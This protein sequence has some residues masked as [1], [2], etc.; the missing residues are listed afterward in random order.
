MMDPKHFRAENTIGA[1]KA[2]FMSSRAGPAALFAFLKEKRMDFE[3]K[4]RDTPE[5]QA[6]KDL[7]SG[8]Y[9]VDRE[10]LTKARRLNDTLAKPL[11]SLGKLEEIRARLW[12]IRKGELSGFKKAVL[13][14]AG[15]N[16]V[17]EERVSFN[18]QDTTHKVCQ[19]IL[20]GRS[21]LGRIAAYYGVDVYLEDLAVL[22]DVEGHAAFKVRRSTGNIRKGPA[23]TR[24][25]AARFVLAGA[26]KTKDLIKDG[27]D[28]IGAG[29]MGVGNT[30]TSSAVI[31]VLTGKEPEEVTGLGSGLTPEGLRHKIQVVGDAVKV[32][33]PY[34]DVLD[35]LSKLGGADICAMAGCY[36]A[37]AAMGIPFV[38]DG[39]IS[40]AALSAAF[41]CSPFVLDYAF[42]SHKPVE[43]GARAVEEKFNLKP[44]L[45][46]D[47]RLGEGSGC[48]IAMDLMECAV[49]TLETMATFQEVSLSEADYIDIRGETT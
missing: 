34:G 5:E 24:E 43:A 35:I 16:G 1:Q 26:K 4:W 27:Y 32:N 39:V 17:C 14:F 10:A 48:P 42:S 18:P 3:L 7:I 8:I 11:G 30:T 31:S 28:L 20:S 37:C 49:F 38:L 19:N 29:E 25:E 21:G 33:V 46:L 6:L 23:M 41:E 9:P 40:L 2:I 45:D 44:M 15:D 13:V 12:A 36:L 47:M 22:T